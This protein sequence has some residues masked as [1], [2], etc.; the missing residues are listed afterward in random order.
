[1]LY[2]YNIL[3]KPDLDPKRRLCG[4][5]NKNVEQQLVYGWMYLVLASS[6]H[7]HN[8]A[9]AHMHCKICKEFDIE[10]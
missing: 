9:A 7:R 8:K 4:H 6:G 3:K 2:Q 1:M 10:V 5:F